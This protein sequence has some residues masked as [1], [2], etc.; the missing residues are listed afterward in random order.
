MTHLNL[1]EGVNFIQFRIT[2]TGGDVGNSPAFALQVDTQ[3]PPSPLNPQPQPAG[4]T[5]VNRFGV[6]WTN[7]TDLNGI[8][9][10]WYKLGAAPTA[11]NDG[12]FVPGTNRTALTDL[13]V[14]GDGIHTVW[15]WL[16][17]GLGHADH[18]ARS[19]RELCPRHP[20]RLPA[21]AT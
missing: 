12:T 4:W 14:P 19:D 7:P 3:P 11:A 6:T 8:G 1:A 5:N 18:T 15:L 13:T 21:P 16:A 9:G 20:A 10:A 17:D 2:D